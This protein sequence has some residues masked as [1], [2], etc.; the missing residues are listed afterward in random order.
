MGVRQED[1]PV[2]EYA[3]DRSRKESA[4]FRINHVL[5]K[6]KAMGFEITHELNE[7]VE[8]PEIRG[9]TM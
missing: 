2:S 7:D 5:E 3:D 6:A 1:V 4:L 9:V 8:E